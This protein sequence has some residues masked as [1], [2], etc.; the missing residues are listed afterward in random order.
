MPA[1]V[2]LRSARA[3]D[4]VP[5]LAPQLRDRSVAAIRQV[6]DREQRFIKVHAAEYLLWLG[7][8]QG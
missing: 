6:L 8:A 4:D 7:Y 3:A 1:A 5:N 2:A